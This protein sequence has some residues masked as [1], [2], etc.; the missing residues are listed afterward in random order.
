MSHWNPQLLSSL[1]SHSY[2]VRW[3]LRELRYIEPMSAHLL[4]SVNTSLRYK[5]NT[6]LPR[7]RGRASKASSGSLYCLAGL[8]WAAVARDTTRGLVRVL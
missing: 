2:S 8:R 1:G 6:A 5:A 4:S 7:G 3:W